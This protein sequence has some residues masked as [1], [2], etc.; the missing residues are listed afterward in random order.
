MW[1]KKNEIAIK[2]D[3]KKVFDPYCP[4]CECFYELKG[5]T[6][7]YCPECGTKLILETVCS[8]C[9]GIIGGS[10]KFCAVCGIKVSIQE[11]K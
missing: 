8:I 3:I 7:S 1:G 5:M 11:V 2:P 9:G 6:Y 10:D 4:V